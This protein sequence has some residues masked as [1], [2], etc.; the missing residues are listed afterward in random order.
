[1]LPT[2]KPVEVEN[3]TKIT[4]L[5][6]PLQTT[7][8]T[9]VPFI[10]TSQEPKPPSMIGFNLNPPAFLPISET[11]IINPS[12]ELKLLPSTLQPPPSKIITEERNIEFVRAFAQPIAP[13]IAEKP[14]IPHH[15]QMRI[16]YPPGA[17]RS[18]YW[19]KVEA[20][21]KSQEEEQLTV[22]SQH[23]S[24]FS[25]APNVY[26]TPKKVIIVSTNTDSNANKD[27]NTIDFS[28]T[29]KTDSKA[30]SSTQIKQSE[31]NINIQTLN[32]NLDSNLLNITEKKTISQN[33]E[34]P[35]IELTTINYLV[36]KEDSVVLSSV[37]ES[38]NE[39]FETLSTPVTESSVDSSIKKTIINTVDIR[40]PI[41]PKQFSNISTQNL[42]NK[43]QEF[44]PAQ[45]E[46]N[47]SLNVARKVISVSS[48]LINNKQ[49]ITNNNKT[50]I[51]I[52]LK[53]TTQEITTTKLATISGFCTC[54]ALYN[55]NFCLIIF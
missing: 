33:I 9:T 10:K 1:M 46:Q 41:L 17:T 35:K 18:P 26:K 36:T 43:N 47:Q 23:R 44:K 40:Q 30:Y 6:G 20:T 31:T 54:L 50:E 3:P 14:K 51:K 22:Q 52:E 4:R 8:T 34:Q 21:D 15:L 45:E 2:F 19:D 27:Y 25:Q 48:D 37:K 49:E 42:F 12:K 55:A 13:E 28:K 24:A 29:E 11:K 5:E 39:K 53:F 7:T 32:S 16:L 38:S